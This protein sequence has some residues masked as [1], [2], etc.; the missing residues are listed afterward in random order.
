MSPEE[1]FAKWKRDAQ[2][3][4][5]E[6]AEAHTTADGELVRRGARNR[7]IPTPIVRRNLC[8]CGQCRAARGEG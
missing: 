2:T 3:R 8:L 6:I 4:E 5:L 1:V 7:P